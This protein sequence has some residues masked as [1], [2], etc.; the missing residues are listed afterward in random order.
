M[1]KLIKKLVR[2]SSLSYDKV[3]RVLEFV[4]HSNKT[5]SKIFEVNDYPNKSE[6]IVKRIALGPISSKLGEFYLYKFEIDD[7]WGEYNVLVKVGK[8]NEKGMPIFKNKENLIV[9]IDSGCETGQRFHDETCECSEQLYKAMALV[10]QRGEGI[11]IN[12]PSQD[13]RGKGLPFKLGTLELQKELGI[14]T[15]EAATT[16]LQLVEGKEWIKK[17]SVDDIDNR[18]YT[19]C[20]GIL[21]YF[22]IENNIKIN[23]ATNNPKKIKAFN[24]NGYMTVT[25]PVIIEPTEHTRKHLLA[26]QKILGHSL[27]L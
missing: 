26:K 1:E 14:D 19:G 20:I 25:L 5:Q 16:M 10:E 8:V 11:I 6:V 2:K 4:L 24:D 3:K 9:R 17:T 22:E 23:I 15:I 13:G 12:I 18:T 21:K 7:R 27:F